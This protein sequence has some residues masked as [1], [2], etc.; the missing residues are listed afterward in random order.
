MNIRAEELY[1]E[2]AAISALLLFGIL[3]A[4]TCSV[5]CSG[6]NNTYQTYSG[7]TVDLG[8]TV[9]VGHDGTNNTLEIK[10]RANVSDGDAT[11]GHAATSGNNSAIVGGSG[12]TWKNYGSLTIGKNGSHNQLIVTSGARVTSRDAC[13]GENPPGHDNSTCVT[14]PGSDWTVNGA[15]YVGYK[16]E[17]SRLSI[18]DGGRVQAAA[19]YV[20]W[21]NQSAGNLLEIAGNSML[22]VTDACHRVATCEVRRGTLWLDGGAVASDKVLVWQ[23]AILG[24]RGTVS[25][26]TLCEGNLFPGNPLGTMVN[27]G[28]LALACNAAAGFEIGGTVADTEFDRVVVNGPLSLG[29]VLTISLVNGFLPHAGDRFVIM[30]GAGVSGSFRDVV[31]SGCPA[32][33]KADVVVDATTVTV[34]FGWLNGESPDEPDDPVE[35]GTTNAA[36]D[37]GSWTPEPTSIVINSDESRKGE[38]VVEFESNTNVAYTLEYSVDIQPKPH[39]TNVVASIDGEGGLMKLIHDN[40]AQSG[41][42]RLKTVKK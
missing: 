25:A 27:N 1:R 42:Y 38:T 8:R 18:L 31:V 2:R 35:G 6:D 26:T 14:G 30:T 9:Y 24:G 34:V 15:L 33:L 40:P 11:I 28:S 17:S 41:F 3:I 16:A 37:A 29:G 36:P 12:S 39:W 21:H 7:A 4:P 22:V 5:A 20:G 10:L 32:D 19:V 13:I 23:N